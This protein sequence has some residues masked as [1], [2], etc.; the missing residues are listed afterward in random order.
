MD[1]TAWKIQQ[2]GGERVNRK[3]IV[4]RP[5]DLKNRKLTLPM[6]RSW[7][8]MNAASRLELNH[9]EGKSRN[10]PGKTSNFDKHFAKVGEDESEHSCDVPDEEQYAYDTV[11]TSSLEAMHALKILPAKPIKESEYADQRYLGDSAT[12][13]ISRN[14]KYSVISQPKSS[15]SP[16]DLGQ[17]RYVSE[18]SRVPNVKGPAV[19]RS[20]KPNIPFTEI[21]REK[22][23]VI[24]SQNPLP[25]PRPLET[26]PKQY[27]PLPPEPEGS[28]QLPHTRKIFS[29]AHTFPMSAKNTRHISVKELNEAHGKGRD[30]SREV[31]LAFQTRQQKPKYHPASSPPCMLSSK[32]F[33]GSGSRLNIQNCSIERSPSP[34]KHKP[35]ECRSQGIYV[36]LPTP[37]LM[38][39]GEKDLNKYDWYS[40]EFDRQKAEEALLQENIDETFLVRDCSTKS[41]AEPY[42]LVIYYGNKVYNIKIRFLEDSQQYALGT[43]LRGDDKFDSVQEIIDFYTCV[44]ITLIDGK[45]KSG[46]Q[47]EQCYLTHPFKLNRRCFLP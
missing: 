5:I 20:M 42:V 46:I 1:L 38:K 45:D 32:S 4:E 8:N 13:H 35:S 6:N 19:K 39:P 18:E 34:G 11:K 27:Q 37:H 21:T 7:P 29:Q 25:P 44:P 33:Q 17:C 2:P 47:R 3:T 23:K 15:D 30:I 36:N 14:T 40:G 10:I 22:E 9:R 16:R 28:S 12:T 43:G 26:L 24:G 31:E 41:S